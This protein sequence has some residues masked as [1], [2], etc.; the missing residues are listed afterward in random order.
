MINVKL[1]IDLYGKYKIHQKT[2][3]L[4]H[5]NVMYVMQIMWS[6]CPHSHLVN[7]LF[8]GEIVSPDLIVIFKDAQ[9]FTYLLLHHLEGSNVCS[10][11]GWEWG[12][13]FINRDL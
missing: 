1:T 2:F 6:I 11:R 3:F 12:L 4:R 13:R 7:I 10:W 9:L 8:Y 5:N